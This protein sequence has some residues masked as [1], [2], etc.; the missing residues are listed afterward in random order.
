[1]AP[2]WKLCEAGDL[3]GL[4]EAV[5]RGQRWGALGRG[6]R[7]NGG[8]RRGGRTGLMWAVNRK[9]NSIVELLLQHPGLDV[10]CQ[11]TLNGYTALHYSVYSDNLEGLRLLLGHPGMRSLNT[12]NEV[13]VTPLMVAVNSGSLSCVRQLVT[14]NW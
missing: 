8:D 1:M 4:R 12:R 9:H 5:G 14:G 13:G 11:A 3:S 2:L 10:N 7:L 6:Q